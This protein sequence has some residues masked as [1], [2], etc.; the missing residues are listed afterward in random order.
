MSSN[1]RSSS[2]SDSTFVLRLSCW[3]V[4]S[5]CNRLLTS[6][7]SCMNGLRSSISGTAKVMPSIDTMSVTIRIFIADVMRPVR[8]DDSSGRGQFSRN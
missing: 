5:D 3:T 4:T 8:R 1:C 6:L 7:F 2:S